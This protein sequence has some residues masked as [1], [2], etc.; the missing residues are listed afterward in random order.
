MLAWRGGAWWRR[1]KGTWIC[2]LTLARSMSGS[3]VNFGVFEL[4]NDP[5]LK[6]RPLFVCVCVWARGCAGEG[7]CAGVG[8]R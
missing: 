1:Y 6:V 5:A 2:L 7:G 4:Y 3:Y 8:G